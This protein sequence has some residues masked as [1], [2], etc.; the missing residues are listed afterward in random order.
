MAA[1][2][3]SPQL[4]RLFTWAEK[5]GVLWPKLAYPVRF[6]PGYIGS[7]ATAD[8]GPNEA[9]VT[10][11]QK[12]LLTSN[13][14]EAGELAEVVRD[15]PELFSRQHPWYEDL[16][17][18]A[19]L[20]HEKGKGESS[21]WAP[22]VAA[23]P[24][25][26]DSV[27]AWSEAELAELQDE[28]LS[29]EVQSRRKELETHWR[30]F[31]EGLRTYPHLFPPDLLSLEQFTWAHWIVSSRSF[32]TKVPGLA[33]GPIAEFLNHSIG[34]TYYTYGSATLLQ[35]S[36]IPAQDRDEFLRDSQLS[37]PASYE[38]LVLAAK[39]TQALSGDVFTSLSHRARELDAMRFL[40]IL[41]AAWQKPEI[42]TSEDAVLRIVTGPEQTYKL[43][44]ELYLNYGPYSNRQLL[45]YYGFALPQ[46]PYAYEYV[47]VPLASI[48]SEAKLEYVRSFQR[49]EK[50]AFKVK[51]GELCMSL[52]RTL[53]AVL[54]QGDN[55]AA[56][57]R[58]VDLDLELQVLARAGALLQTALLRFPTTAEQDRALADGSLSLRA[59]FAV[60]YRVQRKQV[61]S[62]QIHL[63]SLLEAH[64]ASLHCTPSAST[65]LPA[66]LQSYLCEL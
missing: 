13:H 37:T 19:C 6:D 57:F 4:Q 16:R 43:G 3:V 53:R 32:G 60:Q 47:V 1:V 30:T 27:L 28:V 36:P 63:L 56:C 18:F 35:S 33:L 44:E 22:F 62:T 17:L 46:D 5:E 58:P 21:F 9:I 12:L 20:F 51:E 34:S 48:L 55:T 40:Q 54:W 65:L 14:I 29:V 41:T 52:L 39:A 38:L 49:T 23:L 61:L 26:C 50:W 7:Q 25:E 45:I 66:S 15:H 2:H 31:S 10:V 24:Q 64:I 59:T 42:Q 8:I 11:P